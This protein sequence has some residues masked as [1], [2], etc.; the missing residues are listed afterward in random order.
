METSL[1]LRNTRRE[2][3]F[4]L[5]ETIVAIGVLSVGL[6]SMAALMA[7]IMSTTSRSGYVSTAMQLASEKLEDLTI[8]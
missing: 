3:G 4:S 8:S 7:R 6:M 5:I 2:R 1:S